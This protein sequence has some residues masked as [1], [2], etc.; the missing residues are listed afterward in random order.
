M[1]CVGDVVNCVGDVVNC[2]GDVVLVVL[3]M[4]CDLCCGPFKVL[5]VML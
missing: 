4:L 2:V 1:S 3:G 5:L